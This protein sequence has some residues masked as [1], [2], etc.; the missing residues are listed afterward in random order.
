MKNFLI[1]ILACIALIGAFLSR[2]TEVSYQNFIHEK[3]EQ[4]GI[5]LAPQG[6]SAV[7]EGCKY[8]DCWLWSTIEVNGRVAYAGVF[9]RWFAVPESAKS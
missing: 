3:L 4:A 9:S 5:K 7:T 6:K 8:R 1:C 2:P